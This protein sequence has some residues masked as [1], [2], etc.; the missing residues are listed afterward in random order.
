MI[1]IFPLSSK[2][3]Y[4]ISEEDL[5][6]TIE[7]LINLTSLARVKYPML[8]IFAKESSNM[9]FIAFKEVYEAEKHPPE[10]ITDWSDFA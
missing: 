6:E 5:F 2:R 10:V 1:D 9:Q 8:P 3:E 7:Q 4:I